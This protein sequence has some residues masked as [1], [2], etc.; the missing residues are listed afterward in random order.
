[1]LTVEDLLK[2]DEIFL[3]NS[4]WQVLPVRQ[5]EKKELPLI[6]NNNLSQSIRKEILLTIEQTCQNS[7]SR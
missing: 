2:A 7:S 4:Q 5:I 1:M 6:T 3:T